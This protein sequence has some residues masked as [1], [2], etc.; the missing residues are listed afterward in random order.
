MAA[1]DATQA[2][3]F[4]FNVVGGDQV[5]ANRLTI[6]DN[7]TNTVVYQE[8]QETFKYEHTLPA[9][10]LTNGTYYNAT[11]ATQDV[12]GTYSAESVPIQFYCFTQ[13]EIEFTNI[14]MPNTITNSSFAFDFSYNQ[15]EGEHLNIYR[16][17]LYNSYQSLISSSGDIYVED[18]TP[19]YLNSYL[20]NGFENNALYYIELVIETIYNTVVSTGLIQFNVQ[21]EHPDIYSLVELVNNCD[22]GYIVV[23][24]NI[25]AIDGISNPDPPIY[26]DNKE[27]DLTADGSWVKFEQGYQVNGNT[28][29]RWWFRKPNPYNEITRFSNAQ[30]QTIVVRFMN[31]YENRGDIDLKAY[32][33]VYVSSLNGFYYYVYSNYMTPLSDTQYYNLWLKRINN[34][35]EVK[36]AEYVP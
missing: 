22:E 17:N 2:Q 31:G 8:T 29:M 36:L 12:A 20:F 32:V 3:V 34:I 4:G 11:L 26:I 19:P 13:P 18:G 21:Y 15:A 28:L 9:N 16:V 23:R 1:F 24:S 35:Y 33:E 25:V 30:G 5:T 10:T 27:V 6:R 7:A 14:P